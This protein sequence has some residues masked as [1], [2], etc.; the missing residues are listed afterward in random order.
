MESY[1]PSKAFEALSHDTRLAVFRLLIEAGRDGLS[2]GTVGQRL[3]LPANTLSFHFGRLVNAGL[4]HNRRQ[5]RHIYYVVD[6]AR[7]ANLVGFLADDC[8]SAAP[9]GCLPE[10]P[11]PHPRAAT[12][13][14]FASRAPISE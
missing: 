6:Y 10:C 2:A 14:P 3:D 12:V 13:Y 9:E 8:C 1:K 11:C 4:I 5:G 7:L